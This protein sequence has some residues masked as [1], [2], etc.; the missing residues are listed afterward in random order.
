VDTVIFDKTGT[1][2]HDGLVLA[3]TQVRAGISAAQ[4]LAQAAALARHSLHPVSRALVT[5]ATS[6]RASRPSTR[7]A[8]RLSIFRQVS[9]WIGLG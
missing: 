5:A 6:A 7:S 4:A 9:A 3:A 1:L 8:V 2:T